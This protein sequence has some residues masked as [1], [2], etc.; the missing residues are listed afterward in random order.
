MNVAESARESEAKAALMSKAAIVRHY[1][2][3]YNQLMISRVVEKS[4]NEDRHK[5]VH[6]PVRVHALYRYDKTA[7]DITCRPGQFYLLS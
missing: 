7:L 6:V 1:S 4:P 2:S 3:S 5:K